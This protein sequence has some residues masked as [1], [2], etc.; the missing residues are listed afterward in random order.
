MVDLV[1]QDL[2]QWQHHLKSLGY[3][4]LTHRALFGD[5]LQFHDQV[6]EV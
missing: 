5:L 6:A 4:I 3:L 2:I 1:V